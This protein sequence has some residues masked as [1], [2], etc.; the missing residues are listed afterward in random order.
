MNIDKKGW[1]PSPSFRVNLIRSVDIE[2]FVLAD[3]GTGPRSSGEKP[4]K[5]NPILLLILIAGELISE[6]QGEECCKVKYYSWG[7]GGVR[8]N[9]PG[10]EITYQTKD[11]KRDLQLIEANILQS[12]VRIHLGPVLCCVAY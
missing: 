10:A 7:K 4:R 1:T 2:A 11:E 12:G 5:P 8:A 3:Y 9:I 6:K